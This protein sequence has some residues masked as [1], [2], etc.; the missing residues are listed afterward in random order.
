MT[1]TNKV[2]A[3]RL[4]RLSA[5]VGPNGMLPISRSTFY[6][7]IRAGEIPQPIKLGPRISAWRESDIYAL[8]N[9][10]EKGDTE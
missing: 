7:R 6:A 3:E 5:I 2:Q 1:Q 9:Q 10:A 4:M 8:I